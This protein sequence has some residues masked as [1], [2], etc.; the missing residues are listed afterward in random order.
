MSTYTTILRSQ[1]VSFSPVYSKNS[2]PFLQSHLHCPQL[3]TREEEEGSANDLH[4]LYWTSANWFYPVG[5][6]LTGEPSMTTNVAV[7]CFPALQKSV[8]KKTR[9]NFETNSPRTKFI[10]KCK[11]K[12]NVTRFAA[13][14]NFYRPKVKTNYRIFTFKFTIII[15]N[16]GIYSDQ[17]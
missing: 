13:K 7:S 14:Q 6:V 10:R 17:T 9:T 5:I 3:K 2:L 12:W 8:Q 16:L 11:M 1:T 15:K 4:F